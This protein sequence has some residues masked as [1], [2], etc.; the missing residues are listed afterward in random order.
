[1]IAGRTPSGTAAAAAALACLLELAGRD[2]TAP[3]AAYLQLVQSRIRDGNLAER[4]RT[5]VE[6]RDGSGGTGAAARDTLVAVYRDL[7]DCLDA[8]E[9]YLAGRR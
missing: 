9:P 2:A 3:E 1:M 7:A 8:N 4:I 6:R 5:E